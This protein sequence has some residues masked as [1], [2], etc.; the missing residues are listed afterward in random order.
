[1]TNS[2]DISPRRVV[3]TGV[4]LISPLGS[5]AVGFSQALAEGRSGVVRNE[6]L[7]GAELPMRVAG[8]APQ[9][10]GAIGDFGNLEGPK[11]KAI[12]K[13]LKLMCRETKMAVAAAQL[14]IADA[15]FTGDMTPDP[16]TS[17]VVLGSDY[18][19][20]M[21]KDYEAAVAKCAE[22]GS[23][24]FS[25]WGG[26]GLGDM[27]PLWM[28]LYLPNMPASHIA[29][30]NDLRGPNNSLT[31][32]E[33]SGLM[34]MG[35]ALRIVARGHADRMIA[36]ATGTRVLPM[37]AI[38]AMQTESMASDCEDPATACRPFD[39]QRTGMVAGEGSGMV[40]LE[41]LESAQQRGAKIY[42]EVLGFGAS[43]VTDTELRGK[44]DIALANAMQAALGDAG[45]EASS[46]GHINAH[47]LASQQA[48]VDEAKAIAK[49]FGDV[50]SQPPVIAP[51]ANFGNLGAGSGMVELIASLLAFDGDSALAG[52]LPRLINYTEPDPECPVNAV[53]E[54]GSSPGESFVSVNT[55]PQGQAAAVCVGKL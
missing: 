46:I 31:M 16:E 51:K 29:I 40:M 32:R 3:I 55:T 11:K 9:F 34:A 45:R 4:G 20:T 2:N 30:Y 38:H 54:A 15:G 41:S 1:M 35:E 42:G 47:G 43:Q 10:T 14:A 37:Q 52:A 28:L 36:G 8:L 19:L 25:R 12:R 39:R 22:D 17:G 21:P 7:L 26:D 23:F 13:G 6:P 44:N 48:D 53:S 18:M 27:N 24:D 5:S 50:G 49:V 33:A